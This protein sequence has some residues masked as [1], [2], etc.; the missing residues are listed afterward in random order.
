MIWDA[1]DSNVKKIYLENSDSG[2]RL[3]QEL[4]FSLMLGHMKPWP[5]A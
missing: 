3:Y 4:G 5:F 2:R 1:K